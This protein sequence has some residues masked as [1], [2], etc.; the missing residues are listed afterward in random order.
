MLMYMPLK[1]IDISYLREMSDNCPRFMAEVINIYKEQAPELISTFWLGYN[2]A[3]VE[4]IKRAAHK[5]RNAFSV[6]GISQMADELKNIEDFLQHEAIS[7]EMAD[8]IN[9]FEKICQQSII[10]LDLVLESIN[11]HI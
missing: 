2:E 8:F 7:R 4:L 10:E 3:D 1:L 5:A 9:Y 11:A 6:M